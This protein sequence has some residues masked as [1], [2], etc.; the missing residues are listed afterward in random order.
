ME[1]MEASE[2]GWYMIMI[3][4]QEWIV[5]KTLLVPFPLMLADAEHLLEVLGGEKHFIDRRED[6]EARIRVQSGC[7]S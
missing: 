4:M 6:Q 5:R 1:V 7:C 2:A 3:L